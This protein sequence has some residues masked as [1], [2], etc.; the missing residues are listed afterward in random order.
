MM[1]PMTETGRTPS[2]PDFV[3]LRYGDDGVERPYVITLCHPKGGVAKT[4]TV[5]ALGGCFVEQLHEVLMIDLDP[6]GNLTS[7]L[8]LNPAEMQLSA[9]EVMLHGEPLQRASQETEI[10]GLE[11]VPA[12]PNMLTVERILYSRA[13]FEYLLRARLVES[14]RSASDVVLVDCPPALGPLTINALTAADLVIIPLPCEYFAV[15]GLSNLFKL[16]NVVRAKTNPALRYR[17][18]ITMFDLRG[19]LHSRVRGLLEKRYVHC[20]FKNSIGV[21]SKLRESQLAGRPMISYA[22]SS[23]ATQQYRALTQ[24]LLSYVRG[25]VLQAA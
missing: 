2:R 17:L 5:T 25:Q 24:E 7:G 22:P 14:G 21:D 23:R 18:L 10:P 3:P 15:Q 9:A 4:T 16:I 12:N 13:S 8:G 20:L 1:N 19:N 11:I 6:Q